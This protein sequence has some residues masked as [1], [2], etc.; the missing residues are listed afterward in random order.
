MLGISK[1]WGGR[2]VITEKVDIFQLKYIYFD[3][4]TKK[5]KFIFFQTSTKNQT[6]VHQASRPN[7]V[8]IWVNYGQKSF[9]FSITDTMLQAKN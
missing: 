1:L 6:P 5:I 3:F 7:L 4:E 8:Q 9:F 2:G